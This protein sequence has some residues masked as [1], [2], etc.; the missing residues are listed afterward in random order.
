MKTRKLE[1]LKRHYETLFERLQRERLV[2][3]DN[4]KLPLLYMTTFYAYRKRLSA[5]G[6]LGPF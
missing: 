6:P 4:K 2:R 1:C 3:I 5:C